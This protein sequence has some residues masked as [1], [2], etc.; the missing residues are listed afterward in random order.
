MLIDTWRCIGC[1]K[2]WEI[3]GEDPPTQG[4]FFL[5]LARDDYDFRCPN[6]CRSYRDDTSKKF[7]GTTI[8]EGLSFRPTKYREQG[9]EV[10]L[11]IP[12]SLDGPQ[13]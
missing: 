6:G 11:D 4:P 8:P 5:A 10:W 2:T 13:P 7:H 1:G 9:T 3:S 12:A